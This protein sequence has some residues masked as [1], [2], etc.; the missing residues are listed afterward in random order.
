MAVGTSVA[1]RFGGAGVIADIRATFGFM[2]FHPCVGAI[3]LRPLLVHGGIWV[4]RLHDDLA[5]RW[6]GHQDCGESDCNSA[7]HVSLRFLQ[8]VCAKKTRAIWTKFHL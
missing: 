4:W 1:V 8:L 5:H 3:L 6:C 2:P 7:A